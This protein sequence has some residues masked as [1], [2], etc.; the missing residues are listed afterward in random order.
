[1]FIFQKIHIQIVIIYSKQSLNIKP[2]LQDWF[3]LH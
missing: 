2:L 1:M 3:M